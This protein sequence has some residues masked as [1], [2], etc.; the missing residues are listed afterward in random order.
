[1]LYECRWRQW[2]ERPLTTCYN[3]RF[4]D[5]LHHIMRRHGYYAPAAC[6]H[7]L[8][9]QKALRGF[10]IPRWHRSSVSDLPTQDIHSGP[11]GDIFVFNHTVEG[12]PLQV[13]LALFDHIS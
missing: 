13:D 10:W 5:G 12:A 6:C 11:D 2:S 7:S 9:N 8:E 3:D 4:L 1:M